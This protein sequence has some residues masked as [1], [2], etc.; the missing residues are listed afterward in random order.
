MVV[1]VRALCSGFLFFLRTP[2]FLFDRFCV[3]FLSLSP[4]RLVNVL[5]RRP[6]RS[7]RSRA[8]LTEDSDATRLLYSL[9]IDARSTLYHGVSQRP[10]AM[11][12]L[13]GGSHQRNTS[14]IEEG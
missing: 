5:C 2:S 9:T 8:A 7:R 13:S 6:G 12:P 14:T 4:L 3:S 10:T 11:A 1:V